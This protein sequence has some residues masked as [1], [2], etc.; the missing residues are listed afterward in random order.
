MGLK[1]RA[2][3]QRVSL[4]LSV[5]GLSEISLSFWASRYQRALAE[6]T[7]RKLALLV[8]I[9]RYPEEV[10]ECSLS[11]GMA[12]SGCLTDV[13][14]Q[15]ELLIHRF[16]FQ[17]QDILTLTDQQATGEAIANAFLSHL[18][19]Q[20]REGDVVVFH[21]SGYGSRVKFTTSPNETQ[22][23]LVPVDGFLPTEEKPAVNDLLEETLWLLLRSLS[24]NK[25]TTILDTSH[26]DAG[27][28]IEGNLRIRS[29]L[30][31]PTGQPNPRE[32]ALQEQLLERMGLSR[33]RAT[34]QR[35][36]EQT[37]GLRLVAA[38]PNQVA[39]EGQWNGFSAGLFTYALT[40][41]LWW[42]TPASTLRVCLSR[43]VGTME[44]WVGREQ[45]PTLSGYRSREK[46]L[47]PYYLSP[48]L[49]TMADGVVT[50]VEEGGKTGQI[51]LAGLPANVLEHY[52]ENSLLAITVPGA[53]SPEAPSMELD[54]DVFTSF[55]NQLLQV[56]SQDGLTVKAKIC[57]ND[58]TGTKRLEP[59]QLVRE[60]VRVLPRSVE[61]T[62][63]LDP[64]LERIERVDAI[65][66]FSTI[67]HV[68]S[69]MAGEQPADYLFGKT[70]RTTQ[71]L[72]ASLPSSLAEAS[73]SPSTNGSS[74]KNGYGLFS[75]GRAVIP[76]TVGE[77]EEAVKTAVNRL[78]PQLEI[79]LATKLLR[80]TV[81]EGSSRLGV[82]AT[83]ETV[84][85]QERMLMQRETVRTVQPIPPSKLA[86]LF[87]E[88]GEIP[89]LPIDSRVQYRLQN[90]SDRPVY[91]ILLGLDSGGSAIALYPLSAT[92]SVSSTE[93]KLV[94]EDSVI[95]PGETL[96]V[97][98]N[99]VSSGWVIHGPS[100]PAETHLIFSRA[101]LT[102]TFAALDGAMRFMG[103]SRRVTLLSKPLEVVQAVLEDLHKASTGIAEKANASAD[104]YALDVDAW[105][106][107]SFIYQVV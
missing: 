38:Q 21:F 64:S 62:V 85:P 47:L 45:Q 91:F 104:M 35:L 27:K 13:E 88:Q 75:L 48:A 29:R 89:T 61:L 58:V 2:F 17:P 90:Y 102:K 24:T 32:L 4:A 69:V 79:L 106:T 30:S 93:V 8:G 66:A 46:F 101:P 19:D 18:T 39:A 9:N 7:N 10:C 43:T 74:L 83:L 33:E 51:W 37:P 63:A 81:N 41:Q 73:V 56:R 70:R 44:Q 53:S 40:Q 65:S 6:P 67:P 82:R 100:G 31:S 54:T 103:N 3:L 5:L 25:I 98:Q 12:L 16:G 68:S 94:P 42:S 97:P 84:V 72:A 92:P 76:N 57:C 23:S 71:T 34:M 87:V 78:T 14:L 1:R 59:G 96:I 20:A 49:A 80:L 86:S 36:S 28:L 105:A 22:D 26:I 77:G 11:R 95:P 60:I 55:S 50:T 52:G 15:R 107:L 99:S